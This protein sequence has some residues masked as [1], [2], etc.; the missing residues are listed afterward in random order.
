MK[1]D[2]SEAGGSEPPKLPDAPEGGQPSSRVAAVP[3]PSERAGFWRRLWQ[4]LVGTPYYTVL[5]GAALIAAVISLY[6]AYHNCLA[7]GDKQ[8]ISTLGVA[9]LLFWTLGPPIYFFLEYQL[10]DEDHRPGLKESRELASKIWA[11]V[12]AALLLKLSK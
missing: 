8:S 5:G 11:A 6:A 1:E 12:L 10:T 9:V 4:L 7:T 3:A 2:N